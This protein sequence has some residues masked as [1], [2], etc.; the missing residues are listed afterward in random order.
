[1]DNA[2]LTLNT[3]AN[4]RCTKNMWNINDVSQKATQGRLPN[5]CILPG[6]IRSRRKQEFH[7]IVHPANEIR[8]QKN[9][10]Y[11]ISRCSFGQFSMSVPVNV[12]YQNV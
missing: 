9:C 8:L 7:N 5:S 12:V 1:M 6:G 3:I 4:A 11:H 10:K 2:L